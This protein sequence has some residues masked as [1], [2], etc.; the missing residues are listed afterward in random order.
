MRIDFSSDREMMS[1]FGQRRTGRP[2]LQLLNTLLMLAGPRAELLSH[3]EKPW[4]SVTFSGT[5]HTVA[6]LFPGEDGVMAAEEFIAAL[7]D[8]EFEIRSK[9]VADAA[10][11]SVEQTAGPSPSMTIEAELLLLD[12][13]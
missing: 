13:I 8:H 4:A 7:P 6:L 10:V 3:S 11:V 1:T 5:R 2:W 9:L 12:D